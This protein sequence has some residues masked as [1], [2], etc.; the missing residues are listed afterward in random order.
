MVELF[1]EEEDDW[2]LGAEIGESWGELWMID[3]VGG[4]WGGISKSAKWDFVEVEGGVVRVWKFPFNFP[5]KYWSKQG[6]FV[7]IRSWEEKCSLFKK[8]ENISH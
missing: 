1:K 4:S 8:K 7:I 5:K 6:K 2:L 3:G